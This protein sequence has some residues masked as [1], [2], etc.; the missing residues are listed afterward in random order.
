M[1]WIE[2]FRTGKHTSSNGTTKT[3]STKDLEDIALKYNSQ[4]D[5]KAPLVIGHPAN[6]A[7]AFGWTEELRVF[8]DKMFA[9][10]GDINTSVK[11]A[12]KRKEYQN[13]SI[14]I[15]GNGLLRHIG[16]LGAAAPAVAGLQPVKFAEGIT[17]E[18]FDLPFTEDSCLPEGVTFSEQEKSLMTQWFA[19]LHGAIALVAGKGIADKVFPSEELKQFGLNVKQEEEDMDIKELEGKFTALETQFSSLQTQNAT[20]LSSN[21]ALTDGMAALQKKNEDL[22]KAITSLVSKTGAGEF[23]AFL[24]EKVREGKIVQGEV[25]AYMEE[26]A[27]MQKAQETLTFADG[28]KNLVER[29]KDT[30]D[31]KTPVVNTSRKTFANKTDVA[32]TT[33][34]S[35]VPAEF[36]AFG[37]LDEMGIDIDAQAVE[38]MEKHPGTSY[39]VAITK[40]IDE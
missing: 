18:E 17:F 15:D 29:L 2:V 5:R 34:A 11:E 9:F 33:D 28:E 25:P 23:S 20:L 37:D 6:D 8:K 13:I 7:P 38:Y 32:T 26:F 12:V 14:A 39:E 16:L 4:K 36:S 24:A 22:I 35:K 3:W 30:I 31:K 27:L 21:T 19:R 1:A 10:I 40:V